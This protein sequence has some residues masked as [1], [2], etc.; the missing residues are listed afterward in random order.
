MALGITF[1][2]VAIAVAAIW[3]VIEAKRMKH[4]IFA[5]FIIGLI[6]FTYISFSVVLKNNEVDLKT[7]S[8]MATGGKLYLSW[9]GSSFTNLKSITAYAF[10]QDW[11][12]NNITL[13]IKN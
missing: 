10:K 11:K 8:G 13:E 2:L 4:K 3:I 12:Q 6:I 1:I 7:P 9:L 5:I